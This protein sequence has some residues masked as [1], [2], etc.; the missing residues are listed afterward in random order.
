MRPKE[1]PDSRTFVTNARRA[2]I[3]A[4]AIDTVAEVG[5]VN[6]SLARIAAR[7]GISKG[8]ISYHFAG[9]DDLIEEIVNQVVEQGK[10][11]M[12]P[13]ILA[14]STGAA[15][16]RAYIQ[17]NLAFMREHP[18]HLIAIVEIAR[19]TATADGKRRF[20][21]HTDIDEAVAIL[22][23]HLARFQAAGEFRAEFDPRA[24]A[25]AIRAAIDAVPARLALTPRLDIDSY[26]TE[27]ATIF[28]LATRVHHDTAPNGHERDRL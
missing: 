1:E 23:E 7:L 22:A 13:R 20:Y 28:D 9:K 12:R 6:T 5:Y 25:I 21:G 17:S 14:H 26:A 27:I 10:A 11:Y 16:L 4:A 8:V 3:V 2:Q 18:N 24:M 19:N 15:T